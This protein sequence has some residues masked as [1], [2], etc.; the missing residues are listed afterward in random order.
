MN[1]FLCTAFFW[2]CVSLTL[3]YV[4]VET[5]RCF[6]HVKIF[7]RRSQWPRRVRRRSATARLLGLWVPSV[8]WRVLVLA[9]LNSNVLLSST[10]DLAVFVFES[11]LLIQL[12]F[13]I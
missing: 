3:T 2:S 5:C 9:V 1:S 10:L 11:R 4:Y 6:K 8:R 12:S 13:V 7:Y